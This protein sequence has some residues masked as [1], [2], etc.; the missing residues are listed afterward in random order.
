MFAWF[1]APLAVIF[2][3]ATLSIPS[4]KSSSKGK[5]ESDKSEQTDKNSSKDKSDQ[6]N[7]SSSDKAKGKSDKSASAAVSKARRHPR[8]KPQE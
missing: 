4:D 3:L 7:E 1:A 6:T 2:A 5:S 8:T